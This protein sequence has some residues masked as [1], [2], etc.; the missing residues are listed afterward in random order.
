VARV[1]YFVT[2]VSSCRQRSASYRDWLAWNPLPVR[3]GSTTIKRSLTILSLIVLVLLASP[4]FAQPSGPAAHTDPI[5][6][7]PQV[8]EAHEHFYNLDYDGA[9]TRFEAIQRANP[10][11]A[12]ATGYVLM[13]LIFR[14]LY[15]QDL[16]DTTYYAHDSFLTSRRSVPVPQ[17]IRDRIESLTNSALALCDQ[18]IKANPNDANAYFARGYARGM[19]A[20]FITLV[21]HSYVAAARQGYAAR[22]DSEQTLKIDPGYAD[23]KM[24]IGIQQFAVASLPRLIRMMV[25]IAGVSGNKEKGLDLLRESA[26][27]GIVTPIE[28]RTALSLFLRH[29]ARYPEAIVVQKGLAEEYPRD[30]LFRLEVANLIKDSG[31]GPGAIAEYRSIL[32]DAKKPGYFIDPRLHMAYFG[33]ADTQRGQNQIADAAQNY[34]HAAAQPTCSDW[35]RRRA[36]LNA[37]EMFDLLGN[38]DEA[39][40]QYQLASAGGGDQSQADAAHRY[41]KSPYT[42]K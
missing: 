24:A 1:Q 31:N 4:A 18:Q 10:Q 9:L 14:E 13:T 27:H 20:A 30:Y 32:A 22:G 23:A 40:K 11:S 39:V 6:L 15:R 37:G 17:P 2:L 19:H 35:I 21:D 33:L 28:S 5:N 29:D 42:G 38:R 3:I 25:G 26:A 36:Q 16:P 8:R 7:T 41:L 12:I 34:L